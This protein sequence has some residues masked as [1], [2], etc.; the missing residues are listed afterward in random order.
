MKYTLAIAA[1]LVA[2]AGGAALAEEGHVSQAQL[3]EMGLP[4]MTVISDAQGEEIRGQGFAYASS[5]SASALPG[6]FTKNH[7]QAL[8]FKHADAETGAASTFEADILIGGKHGPK[9]SLQ[10]KKAVGS[11]GFAVANSK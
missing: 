2:G 6:T 9:F 8:G 1:L 4:G 5:V 10:I 11:A 7:A 3:A